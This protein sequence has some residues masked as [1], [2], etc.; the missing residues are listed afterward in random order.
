M[1]ALQDP[2]F[3]SNSTVAVE[4]YDRPVSNGILVAV[5]RIVYVQRRTSY[6]YE[7]IPLLVDSGNRHMAKPTIPP[8]LLRG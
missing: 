1:Q 3:P 2:R 4:G 7:M 6:E 8:I 5:I